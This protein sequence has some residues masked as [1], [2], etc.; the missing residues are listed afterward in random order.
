MAVDLNAIP[1]T[2][3]FVAPDSSEMAAAL[4]EL[5]ARVPLGATDMERAVLAVAG[6][7]AGESKNQR[8]VVYIGDG[9]SAANILG[10]ETFEKLAA[11]LADARIAVNSY[12]IGARVYFPLLGALAAQSGGTVIAD[13]E[14][15]AGPDAGRLLA[16]AA[17][18]GVLWPSSVAWPAEMTAVFPKRL[19]PLRSDRETI[20]VGT[21]KGKGPF[22]VQVGVDSATGPQKLAFAVTPSASDDN[23][24]YL[25]ALVEQARV[26]GGVTLPLVGSAS[27]AEARRMIGAA[28]NDLDQLAQQALQAGNLASAEQIVSEALRRDPNDPRALAIKGALAKRQ[29]AGGA[30]GG[31]RPC[32]DSGSA[33]CGATGASGAGSRRPRRSEP[34]R[35]RRGRAAAGHHGRRFP[36]RSPDHRP[37]DSGR[38][39]ELDQPGPFAD[40]H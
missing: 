9:R 21:F 23:N 12:L 38:S 2:K 8:A 6:S 5:D 3:T 22:N 11:Q 30:V 13:G 31:G 35:P 10:T 36:A 20:V 29:A 27:L 33:R 40:E 19:P 4:K 16:A 28:V 15:L 32:G 24:S 26:D 7:F 1:L 17:D 25:T 37:G 39:A 14:P 34:R 18:A